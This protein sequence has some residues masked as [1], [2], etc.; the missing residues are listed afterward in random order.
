MFLMINS[1]SILK[2]Q[3]AVL[4]FLTN[5]CCGFLSEMDFQ[6]GVSVVG[7]CSSYRRIPIRYFLLSSFFALTRASRAMVLTSTCNFLRSFD[8]FALFGTQSSNNKLCEAYE[9]MFSFSVRHSKTLYHIIP[10]S[11]GR[12]R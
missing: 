6:S 9:N 5:F 4:H 10:K 2:E 7:G 11:F 3:P 8:C 1:H 12:F